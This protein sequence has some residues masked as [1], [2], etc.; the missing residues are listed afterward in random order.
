MSTNHLGEKEYRT[1]KAWMEACKKENPNATFDGNKDICAAVPN[2][3]EWDG[4][5]GIIYKKDI[6]I[7][8]G[9]LSP[10]TA[11]VVDDY[12]YGFRLRCKMRYWL[13]I[14]PQRGVRGM[15]QTSNPKKEGLVW[16]KPKASN[17]AYVSAA[18]FLENGFVNISM[19]TEYSTLAEA[20][21]FEKKYGEGIPE[22]AKKRLQDWIA[23]KRKYE[24]KIK[25]GMDYNVAG[26]ETILETVKSGGNTFVNLKKVKGN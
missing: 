13:E 6:Q 4:E 19:L 20:L 24:A 2:V 7:L 23:M 5:V 18:M 17:Y 21:D 16:N 22:G 25:N 3:G 11:Y 8:K 14:H 10:E 15:S 12:P 9:H 26:K 1:Y